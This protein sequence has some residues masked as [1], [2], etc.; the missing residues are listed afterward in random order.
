MLPLF[1]VCN[2]NAILCA[3]SREMLKTVGYTTFLTDQS[4]FLPK[5][6]IL[7]KKRRKRLKLFQITAVKSALQNR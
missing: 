4:K 5:T 7:L 2:A 1:G 3:L 6:V